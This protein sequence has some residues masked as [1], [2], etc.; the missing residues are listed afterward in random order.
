MLADTLSQRA[1]LTVMVVYIAAFCG[2]CYIAQGSYL[3]PTDQ[4]GLWFYAAIAALLLGGFIDQP[5]FT[6]PNDAMT[7]AV[8]AAIGIVP[9]A[10]PPSDAI[11]GA[12]IIRYLV[13]IAVIVVI[14]SSALAMWFVSSQN[15]L[16]RSLSQLSARVSGMLGAP[17]VLFSAVFVYALWAFHSDNAL[18]LLILLSGWVF[19]IVGRPLEHLVSLAKGLRE[20]RYQTSGALFGGVIGRHIPGIILVK[21]PAR[22]SAGLCDVV[23]VGNDERTAELAIALDHVG[24]AEGRWLRCVVLPV[25]PSEREQW[26][27]QVGLER[28]APDDVWHFGR[29]P[30]PPIPGSTLKEREAILGVVAA[31]TDINELRFEVINT[32]VDL[33]EGDL[34]SARVGSQDVLYQILNGLTKRRSFNRK[35]HAD[36]L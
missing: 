17:R 3:P 6:K 24:T 20:L 19:L 21:H 1:R 31:E 5:F 27:N 28:I 13:L 10:I 14:L 15:E 18:E 22:R 9:I 35:T 7:N 33:A 32:N 12:W 36:L 30:N 25:K 23:A 11:E 2:V 26:L 4:N 16:L 8:G 34:V 29:E